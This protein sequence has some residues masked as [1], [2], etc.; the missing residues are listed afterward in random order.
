MLKIAL[1]LFALLMLQNNSQKEENQMTYKVKKI[2][3]QISIDAAWDKEPWKSIEA[4]HL[5]H[6]MGEKPS[7]IPSVHAKV[8]Y[9]ERAIYVIFQVH[10]QYVRAIRTNHQDGVFKDSCVE[11][12]FSP[13]K[14]SK[15][16]YFNLEMNCGGTML[17]H[18]QKEPRAGEQIAVEDIAKIEVAHSLPST[19]DPEI[20][21]PVTWTVEYRI[22]FEVL[23][24]YTDLDK[25]QPGIIWRGN[26]YKCADETSHP[27]WLTWSRIDYPRPNF[28]LPEFFGTLQF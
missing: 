25:P 19:V 4:L 27:H 11:F 9:D 18:F 16:G 12:F 3:Q 23:Q 2:D 13:K 26:F 6:F 28:H 24:K 10:D 17:F 14:D 7:H 22:P 20:Q 1:I 5:S 15:D 21:T 8:A